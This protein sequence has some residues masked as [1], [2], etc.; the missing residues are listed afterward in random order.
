[1]KTTP[2]EE[3]I[4]SRLFSIFIS[5]RAVMETVIVPNQEPD[6]E[7]LRKHCSSMLDN[8][9]PGIIEDVKELEEIATRKAEERND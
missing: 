8:G 2:K 5:Y 4:A 3:Q 6:W 1:M 7:L 9:I